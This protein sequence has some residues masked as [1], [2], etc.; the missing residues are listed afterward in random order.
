ML[1][2]LHLFFAPSGRTGQLSYWLAV[3]ALLAVCVAGWPLAAAFAPVTMLLL[4]YVF[5]CLT[6]K[7][8]RDVGVP[9][10]LA[11]V[12]VAALAGYIGLVGF[13]S[14]LTL[15][16]C[17]G[18]SGG[19]PVSRAIYRFLTGLDKVFVM[20]L[21]LT[22]FVVGLVPTPSAATADDPLISPYN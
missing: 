9:G 17:G 2:P 20:A 8:F 7:R 11:A 5:T 14:L 13:F 19:D 3:S 1:N 10:W 4:V 16:C 21:P 12:P 6:A 22:W 18:G 15:G